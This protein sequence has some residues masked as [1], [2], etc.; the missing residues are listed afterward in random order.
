[1]AEKK[2]NLGIKDICWICDGW[3]QREFRWIPGINNKF[4]NFYKETANETK[5]PVHIHM[6]FDNYSEYY[7]GKG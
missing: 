7:M 6:D 1:M 5:P 4:I 2:K 3:M